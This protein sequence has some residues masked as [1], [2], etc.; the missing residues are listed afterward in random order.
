VSL[1]RIHRQKMNFIKFTQT[2]QTIIY[3]RVIMTFKNPNANAKKKKTNNEDFGIPV[4][5]EDDIFVTDIDTALLPDV[6]KPWVTSIAE[7]LN[8]ETCAVAIPALH[9]VMSLIGSRA[10]IQMYK[11]NEMVWYPN[12]F[13]ML[14]GKPSAMKSPTLKACTEGLRGINDIIVEYRKSESLRIKAELEKVSV[15]INNAKAELKETDGSG[16]KANSI[17]EQ[18][19]VLYQ[20]EKTIDRSLRHIIIDDATIEALL[21]CAQGS[22][23]GVTV[24]ADELMSFIKTFSKTGQEDKRSTVLRLFD[25]NQKIDIQRIGRGDI[26]IKSGTLS[27]MGGIQP[28]PLQALVSKAVDPTSTE[29]DGLMQRFQMSVYP[30]EKPFKFADSSIELPEAVID[31][32]CR[33]EKE[34]PADLQYDESGGEHWESKKYKTDDSG[35]KAWEEWLMNWRRNTVSKYDDKPY[36]QAHFIK[37][38]GLCAQ[39]ALTFA[40]I[41]NKDCVSSDEVV[42]AGQW[43]EYIK[44]HILKIYNCQNPV[45]SVSKKIIGKIKSGKIKDGITINAIQKLTTKSQRHIVPNALKQCEILDWVRLVSVSRNSTKVHIN[46]QVSEIYHA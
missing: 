24:I 34:L 2:L 7:A 39:L 33:I 27:L 13:G 40:I 21:N 9:G 4:E 18:L 20:E 19:H 26:Q 11:Q 29:A 38:Q 42:L 43:V 1:I 12:T 25:G 45:D 5:I 22:P 10:G 44:Q 32:F 36:L 35:K 3:E 15:K 28:G 14:V 17:T 37:N 23:G 31:L 30:N 41:D 8:V 16:Q 6:L 46:P